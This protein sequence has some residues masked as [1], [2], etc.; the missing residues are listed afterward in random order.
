MKSLEEQ[1]KFIDVK[2]LPLF[3]IN[4]LIDYSNEAKSDDYEDDDVTFLK[5]INAQLDDLKEKFPVKNF[6]FHKTKNKILSYSQAFRVLKLCLEIANIPHC[7]TQSTGVKAL[8][9]VQDNI[10][11]THYIKTSYRMSEKRTSDS[12]IPLNDFLL[13]PA[14]KVIELTAKDLEKNTKKVNEATIYLNRF[15]LLTNPYNG[16]NEY[17]IDLVFL[18]YRYIKSIKM[19]FLAY[20]DAF[21][22]IFPVTDSFYGSTYQ[23]D[24]FVSDPHH[25]MCEGKLVK[26]KNILPDNVIL[27]NDSRLVTFKIKLCD[28]NVEANPKYIGIKMKLEYLVFYKE[29]EETLKEKDWSITQNYHLCNDDDS[30]YEY[31]ASQHFTSISKNP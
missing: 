23:I 31:R 27:I 4:N 17:I 13:K 20:P 11:L 15:E 2:L 19:E 25:K 12:L 5:K 28:L 21:G 24:Q 16:S 9:L 8:R 14:K 30:Q 3:G 26:N 10:V 7:V 22:N 29:F 6:N 18:K 1:I